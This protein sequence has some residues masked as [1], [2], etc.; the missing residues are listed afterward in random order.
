M[1]NCKSVIVLFRETKLVDQGHGNM[2]RQFPVVNSV[3]IFEFMELGSVVTEGFLHVEGRG[4]EELVQ[5]FE[6]LGAV[7]LTEK[8]IDVWMVKLFIAFSIMIVAK[9]KLTRCFGY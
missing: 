5:V 3:C 2:E 4:C 1:Q 8:K 9:D 6:V 7:Q